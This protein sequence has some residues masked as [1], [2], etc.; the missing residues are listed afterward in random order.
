MHNLLPASLQFVLREQLPVL[1]VYT[2]P[3]HVTGPML[4]PSISK[5]GDDSGPGQKSVNSQVS[6][7]G[8]AVTAVWHFAVWIVWASLN[9]WLFHNT[10]GTPKAAL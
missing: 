10:A 1:T 3:P 2:L 9:Q 4:D 6:L 8:I 7:S 5:H